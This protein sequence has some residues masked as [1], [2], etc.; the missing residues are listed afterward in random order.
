MLDG[1]PY[2]RRLPPFP[3]S[4]AQREAP[5]EGFDVLRAVRGWSAPAASILRS[6]RAWS[7]ARHALRQTEWET[8]SD[9]A[10]TE[11][12]ADAARA[13]RRLSRKRLVLPITV[14]RITARRLAI[15]REITRRVT[16]L[17]PHPVQLAAASALSDRTGVEMA[18]GEGKTLVTSMAA[19]LQAAEG[20]PV[21]VITANDY[22]ALRDLEKGAPLFERLGL[23]YAGIDPDSAPSERAALYAADIVYA[24]SKEIAFD[25]LR[26]RIAFGQTT[27][28][29]L[30]LV[31]ALGTG[32]A[33]VMRGLWSA[34]VDEADSV[35]IDE[36]RTPLVISA[37]PQSDGPEAD[38]TEIAFQAVALASGLIPGADL[39][40]ALGTD[41]P[42]TLTQAGLETVLASAAEMPGVWQGQRRAR[43]LVERALFA[44][45]ILRRDVHYIVTPEDKVEIVDENTGRIMADRTWSDGLHQMVEVKEGLDPSEDRIIIGRLTFQRFFRRYRRLSGLSGTLHEARAELKETYDLTI[46]PVP[47][48]RP[49]RRAAGPVH[50]LPDKAAKWQAVARAAEAHRA[51][52]RPVLIGTSSVAAA[53]DC[54]DALAQ[55]AI[56]HRVLSARQ[57]AQEAEVIETAGIA[58]TVTVATN[59]AGRGADI[60]L[61]PD[62][63]AAGGLVVLLAQ[64]HEA[65]RIDRQLIGRAARQ[66]DPGS[67]ESFLSAEDE[68]LGADAPPHPRLA[69]FD[70][71]QAR[72]EKMHAKQRADLARMEDGLDD[73]TAFTGG[74]E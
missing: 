74:L 34:I 65:G 13:A 1:S 67:Y 14:H 43:E 36:A 57:S 64:R 60:A 56:A 40:V 55:H 26:D 25:H 10:L 66:G 9:D 72:L 17:L 12:W 45:H 3:A 32:Q 70:A 73:M 49:S 52:G 18:T 71:A 53:E 39:I 47:T 16:G 62:A 8:A 22:L 31:D 54:S 4:E 59:M 20:W 38:L 37:I 15:L 63:R 11:A 42:V 7:L 28:L 61:D 44:L 69:D 5:G 58:G 24:S 2:L 21:H 51:T 29:G 27:G 30:R 46:M 19:A 41:H 33:P 48:H 50:I 23:S 6:R 35:M 68:I